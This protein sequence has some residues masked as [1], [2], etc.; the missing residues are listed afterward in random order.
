[1]RDLTELEY[2]ELFTCAREIAAKFQANYPVVQ[3]FTFVMHD[4]ELASDDSLEGLC[5]QA[6][7]S[8]SRTDGSVSVQRL[9]SSL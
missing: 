5:L 8:N 6:I 2:L 9:G 7:P 3:S 1:M 4:G